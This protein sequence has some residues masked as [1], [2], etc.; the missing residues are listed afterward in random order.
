MITKEDIEKFYSLNNECDELFE[1][2][3]IIKKHLKIK[4]DML[5]MENIS[6]KKNKDNFEKIERWLNEYKR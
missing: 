2:M 4:G 3:L 1:I 5:V 6:R